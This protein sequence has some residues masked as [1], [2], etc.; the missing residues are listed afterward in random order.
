MFQA[1]RGTSRGTFSVPRYLDEAR[2]P[3][4]RPAAQRE[5]GLGLPAGAPTE[6]SAGSVP[7]RLTRTRHGLGPTWASGN[8]R[9]WIARDSMLRVARAGLP[10]HVGMRPTSPALDEL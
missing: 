1:R 8:E 9:C 10:G 5:T 7:W 6:T 2:Q 4:R 3:G